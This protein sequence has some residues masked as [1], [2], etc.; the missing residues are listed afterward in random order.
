MWQDNR[1]L[2][3]TDWI[4]YFLLIL[5]TFVAMMVKT[6]V[7]DWPSWARLALTLG[8]WLGLIGVGTMLWR[9]LARKRPTP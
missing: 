7:A 4:P 3:Q 8:I 1:A 6:T 9:W 5:A 2:V